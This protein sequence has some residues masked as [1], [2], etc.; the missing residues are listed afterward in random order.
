MY[1]SSS[2][3]KS[4][5]KPKRKNDKK[6]DLLF[7][8][9]EGK[10]KEGSLRKS[11]KLKDDDKALSMRDINMLLKQKVGDK[12]KFRGN[13]VKVTAIMMKRLNLAKNMM[14]KSKKK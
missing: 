1:S 10:V 8:E 9:T 5:A 4:V 6:E 13:D 2:K 11:L 12:V 14:S 7:E 3:R